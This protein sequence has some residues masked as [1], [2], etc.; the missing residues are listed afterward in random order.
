MIHRDGEDEGTGGG[1]QLVEVVADE[2]VG[3]RGR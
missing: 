3:R 2:G 1:A